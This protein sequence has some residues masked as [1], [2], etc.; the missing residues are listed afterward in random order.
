MPSHFLNFPGL[1]TLKTH[2]Y[3]LT[4]RIVGDVAR[5]CAMGCVHGPTGT[6]KT[7]AVEAAL[8]AVEGFPQ[9]YC[10]MPADSNVTPFRL[11]CQLYRAITGAEPP[12][13]AKSQY[14]LVDALDDYLAAP[15][16]LLVLDEAQRM[17]SRCL[18]LVRR[19][20]DSRR[21][22]FGVLFVGGDGCWERLSREPMLKSRI[23]RRL[24]FMPLPPQA[25]PRWIRIF[26]A[27]YRRTDPELL[28]H[29]DDVYAE[30]VLRNW[31]SFTKSAADMCDEWG[32]E[33]VDEEIVKNVLALMGQGIEE[34][35]VG[36]GD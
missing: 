35:G 14:P 24:P 4:Q 31:T 18:D 11:A 27:I 30:G 5:A 25:V 20:Y 23:Y 32:K 10:A 16:R 17:D 15:E 33:Y 21:T 3:Q 7:F 36:R 19:L 1:R 8:E 22:H 28:T 34:Y 13:K 9:I 26:H 12:S 29:I 2:Q 6:G